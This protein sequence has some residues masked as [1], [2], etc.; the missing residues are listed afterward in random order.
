LCQFA[1]VIIDTLGTTAG[2]VD[3]NAGTATLIR[4]GP[5]LHDSQIAMSSPWPACLH[6]TI[7]G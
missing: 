2:D 3:T 5:R 1:L 7:Q 4:F 6:N